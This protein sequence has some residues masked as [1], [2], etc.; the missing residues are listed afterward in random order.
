M[1]STGNALGMG[2]SAEVLFREAEVSRTSQSQ[3]VEH[4]RV[5][6]QSQRALHES[7]EDEV[8]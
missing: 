7:E 6:K 1:R 5:W 8:F 3:F 2:S 4:G